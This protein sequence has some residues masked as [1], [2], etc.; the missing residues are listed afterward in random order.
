MQGEKTP[1]Q[2][3]IS[4]LHNEVADYHVLL[5][6]E[7]E[8]LILENSSTLQT[9]NSVPQSLGGGGGYLLFSVFSAGFPVCDQ[10]G[11][12][13]ELLFVVLLAADP[14]ADAP[15]DFTRK[16]Q[17]ECAASKTRFVGR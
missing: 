14:A 1:E 2:N 10:K 17:T 8:A 5:G 11:S 4:T 15:T 12:L 9:A 7:Q 3:K 6:Y 16:L 13:L